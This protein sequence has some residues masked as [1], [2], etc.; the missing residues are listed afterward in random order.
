[1]GF[2]L[3]FGWVSQVQVEVELAFKGFFGCNFAATFQTHFQLSKS[4]KCAA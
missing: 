1:M 3:W 2:G 4:S